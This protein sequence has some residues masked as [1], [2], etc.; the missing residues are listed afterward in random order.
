MTQDFSKLFVS[1]EVQR[2]LSDLGIVKP[3]SIQEKTI[4]LM[5]DGQDIIAIAPTGTG[6][7]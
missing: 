6:K 2:D 1:K 3:T 4:P 7:P 5:M